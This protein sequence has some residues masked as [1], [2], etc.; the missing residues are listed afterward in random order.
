MERAKRGIPEE[1]GGEAEV[2]I[3]PVQDDRQEDGAW[4]ELRG[5]YYYEDAQGEGLIRRLPYQYLE[6]FK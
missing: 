1:V 5:W 4:Q 6:E 2:G 3:R